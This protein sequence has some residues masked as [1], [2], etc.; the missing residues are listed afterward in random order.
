MQNEEFQQLLSGYKEWLERINY[1]KATQKMNSRHLRMFFEWLEIQSIE[2]LEEIEL[3]DLELY[4]EHL[5]QVKTRNGQ[6]LEE[7]TIRARF[8]IIKS[9]NK[10][11]TYYEYTPISL[12]PLIRLDQKRKKPD[13]L[14]RSAII[15]MYEVCGNDERG[16]RDRA[17]LTLYYGCGLR[18][19]EGRNLKLGDVDVK[20]GWIKIQ[21]GKYY[22]ER[23]VPLTEKGKSDL[24][25][26]LK[27]GRSYYLKTSTEYLL[28]N[29]EGEQLGEGSVLRIIKRL[30]REAEI[31][32][33]VFTHLLRHSIAT[34][35]LENGMNLE[36]IQLFLGH[37]HLSS[38]QMYTHI[39][40][41]Q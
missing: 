19:G 31:E 33:R 5:Y 23:F 10:Y 18:T 26:Y 14:S 16:L 28:L 3:E 35:L 32:G 20:N 9:L 29:I 2:S 15:A 25:A 21:K 38:T 7:T 13:V 41:G 11:L 34:H 4:K 1:A 17:I 40:E 27:H 22:L 24:D 8:N 30:A 39:V 36:Q 6:A 37:R 12:K